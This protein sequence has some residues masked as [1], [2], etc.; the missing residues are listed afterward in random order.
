MHL[1]ERG[2]YRSVQTNVTQPE[3]GSG[4]IHLHSFEDESFREQYNELRDMALPRKYTV[5]ALN[6]EPLG[7]IFVGKKAKKS[8][9]FSDLSHRKK[10]PK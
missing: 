1:L 9:W 8:Q 7:S 4:G 3:R 10:S 5:A 6:I 2:V